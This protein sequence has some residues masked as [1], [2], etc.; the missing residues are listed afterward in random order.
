M[1][2]FSMLVGQSKGG[3]LAHEPSETLASPL[4]VYRP[5]LSGIQELIVRC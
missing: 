5:V 2:I 3:A 4:W 1:L